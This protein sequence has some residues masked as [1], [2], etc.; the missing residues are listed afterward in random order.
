MSCEQQTLPVS[1][2]PVVQSGGKN[3]SQGIFETGNSFLS[4]VVVGGQSAPA[5]ATSVQP[6]QATEEGLTSLKR[7]GVSRSGHRLGITAHQ[8]A[9]PLDLIFSGGSSDGRAGDVAQIISLG[10]WFKSSSPVQFVRLG[11][12]QRT[13][14][15]PVRA[16]RFNVGGRNR[17]SDVRL[18]GGGLPPCR[19]AASRLELQDLNS[20]HFP[21]QCGYIRRESGLRKPCILPASIIC[22]F[23]PRRPEKSTQGGSS[24]PALH[25]WHGDSQQS[26]V[27]KR[28]RHGS[29]VLGRLI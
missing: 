10:R 19:K 4:P 16:A 9:R 8:G 13:P 17:Q 1:R 22:R 18:N 24:S 28:D 14:S 20:D 11:S 2:Q 5:Q 23:H 21:L 27:G 15:K 6:I 29:V 7:E 25:G 12:T 3:A 26:P